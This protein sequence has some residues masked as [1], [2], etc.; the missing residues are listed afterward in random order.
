MDH[1]T[2]N[3]GALDLS[4]PKQRS[5]QNEEMKNNV[6]DL[7]HKA[8]GSTTSKIEHRTHDA[9]IV[10][11][12]GSSLAGR[13]VPSMSHSMDYYTAAPN[14]LYPYLLRSWYY[15]CMQ[16][17]NKQKSQPCLTGPDI[18]GRSNQNNTERSQ[19]LH[20]R[21]KLST[22][23]TDAAVKGKD[24][25]R[26]G[27]CN[28]EFDLRDGFETNKNNAEDPHCSSQLSKNEQSGYRSLP[29]PLRKENGKIVYECNVCFKRFGQ[30]SNLKVHLRV[31]TGERPF[32]CATCSKGFTQ[33]AHLQKHNLVHTGEKP[34][35]CNVCNK[36]FS[37]TSNL[38][39][40]MRLHNSAIKEPIHRGDYP[41]TCKVGNIN[42]N[43]PDL[44][45][46]SFQTGYDTHRHLMTYDPKNHITYQRQFNRKPY[47]QHIYPGMQEKPR[48]TSVNLHDQ[49][50]HSS[51]YNAN[52]VA[53]SSQDI[54]D[55]TL[56]DDSEISLKRCPPVPIF[57]RNNISKAN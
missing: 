10:R 45:K 18:A 26:G 36:R 54:N 3:I 40:H 44:P 49:E 38:K 51:A 28:N 12:Q 50:Q 11:H 6:L 16:R 52:N 29:Y 24:L 47:S 30:L 31:H 15:G 46:S 23:R 4:V 32:K 57:I 55:N 17:W 43:Q 35:E 13:P 27:H 42:S 19:S 5:G 48:P 25:K 2:D 8:N 21:L 22:A 14:S 39:T 37:S 41:V 33:L 7:S 20:E 1:R 9:G 53:C 56:T 34:H